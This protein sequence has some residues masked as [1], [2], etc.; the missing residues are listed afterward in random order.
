LKGGGFFAPIRRHTH[1][2]Q[3]LKIQSC[4]PEA[5]TSTYFAILREENRT[6]RSYYF[7]DSFVYT[8]LIVQLMISSVL[9]VLGAL[10]GPYHIQIV[11]LSAVSGVVCG[12]L[13]LIKGQGLPIRQLQYAE[14]LR[15][16]REDIEWSERLLRTGYEVVTYSDA[17]K[18]RQAYEVCRNDSVAN[19]PDSWQ[20]GFLP[21]VGGNSTNAV[22]LAPGAAHV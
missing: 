10:R 18:L 11:A 19:H 12:I 3:W 14:Q 4:H 13:S 21:S 9:I 20:G 1:K 2:P 22:K 7:Y 8:A 15:R 16:V 17:I 5:A 6:W